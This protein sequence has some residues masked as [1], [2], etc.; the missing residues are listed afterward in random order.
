MA[1]KGWR[2]QLSGGKAVKCGG[3]YVFVFVFDCVF[4]FDVGFP[5]DVE[6]G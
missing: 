6:D 2:G 3:L 5:V 1:K 4:G